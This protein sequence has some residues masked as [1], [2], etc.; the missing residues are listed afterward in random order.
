SLFTGYS[1]ILCSIYYNEIRDLVVFNFV[2]DSFAVPVSNKTTFFQLTF[3]PTFK[4]WG[5]MGAFDDA[6]SV[7]FFGLAWAGSAYSKPLVFNGGLQF[8]QVD[9]STPTAIS[10][11]WFIKTQWN[12][13]GRPDLIKD[14]DSFTWYVRDQSSINKPA[15]TVVMY[16]DFDPST[17]RQ[18][19][20]AQNEIQTI[21]PS[22]PP[23]AG[24]WRITYS[25]YETT[26]LNW[27]DSAATIQAALEALASI[28]S[29][30]VVV[31]GTLATLVT[32]TFQGTLAGTNLDPVTITAN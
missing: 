5:K 12:E 7:Q 21:T 1:K 30:N 23:D 11:P 17:A 6:V 4:A 3:C 28:G 31:T 24:L 22:T 16:S 19:F 2:P 25:G 15:S 32:L 10:M 13:G 29:G 9:P 26:D 18:T 20:Q 8:Y 14:H 27:N